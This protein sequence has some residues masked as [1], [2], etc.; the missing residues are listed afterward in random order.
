MTVVWVV[1]EVM[2]LILFYQLPSAI[3][4]VND[5][6]T[7]TGTVDG[8]RTKGSDD[9]VSEQGEKKDRSR[10]GERTCS[11]IGR[12]SKNVRVDAATGEVTPLLSAQ[13][14]TRN[15]S[16]NRIS[17]HLVEGAHDPVERVGS[18]VRISGYQRLMKARHYIVFV[19]SQT[20]REEIVVLLAVLFLT[21]FSQT[22][23]EVYIHYCGHTTDSTY[24]ASILTSIHYFYSVY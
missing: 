15:Y 6:D 16:M 23:I 8:E 22:A 10:N 4:P 7:K 9:D 14:I 13:Q 24:H 11:P 5:S 19:A 1:L 21:V 17:E 18:S 12:I 3:E 2:F 20:V